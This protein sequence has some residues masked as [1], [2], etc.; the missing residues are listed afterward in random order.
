M[1][2]MIVKINALE[3]KWE[4]KRNGKKSVLFSFLVIVLG[5]DEENGCV[6]EKG[7]HS[8]FPFSLHPLLLSVSLFISAPRERE[9]AF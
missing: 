5:G 4:K 7:K 9:R 8:S 6:R 2:F 3:N 1:K